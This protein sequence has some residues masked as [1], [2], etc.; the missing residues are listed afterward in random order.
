MAALVKR[1][2]AAG[3]QARAREE[4]IDATSGEFHTRLQFR[5][6]EMG[7]EKDAGARRQ[8]GLQVQAEIAREINGGPTCGFL[9]NNGLL[10]HGQLHKAP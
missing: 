10:D 1:T 8:L 3:R 4:L 2:A 6:L 7:L 9:E 5:L